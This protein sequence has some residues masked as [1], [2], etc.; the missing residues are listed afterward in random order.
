M[1]GWVGGWV[2]GSAGAWVSECVLRHKTSETTPPLMMQ[3]SESIWST[4]LTGPH[5]T[6]KAALKSSHGII[7]YIQHAT[8]LEN[9][10]ATTSRLKNGLFCIHKRVGHP[11]P[12]ATRNDS[13]LAS[14]KRLVTGVA[15]CRHIAERLHS[16]RCR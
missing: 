5:T 14:N 13:S 3:F 11:L 4:L 2:G 9:L 12:Y 15:K 6:K 7:S 16:S 8:A 10:A 1:G